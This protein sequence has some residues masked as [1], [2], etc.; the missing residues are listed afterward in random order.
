MNRKPKRE[1]LRF[2]TVEYMALQMVIDSQLEM[3]GISKR[4]REALLRVVAKTAR[5]RARERVKR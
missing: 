4:Y 1:P 2:S 3:G 5:A